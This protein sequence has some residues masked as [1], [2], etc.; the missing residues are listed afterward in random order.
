MRLLCNGVALDLSEGSKMSFKKVNPLF[1]FDSLT[2]ERTQAFDLPATPTNDRV[3]EL[4]KIPA[5]YGAGMRQRFDAELQD[6]TVVKQGYLYV[7]KYAKGKYSAVFVTGELFGLL[8]IKNAG[9]I[10]ELITCDEA[11]AWSYAYVPA[12]PSRQGDTWS[13]TAY[14]Q[15]GGFLHPSYLVRALIDKAVTA[16]TL[17][18]IDIPAAAQYLRVIPAKINTLQPTDSTFVRTIVGNWADVTQTYPY[19]QI[20]GAAITSDGTEIS[21]LFG[22]VM[23]DAIYRRHWEDYNFQTMQPVLRNVTYAGNVLHLVPKQKVKLTFPADFPSDTYIGSFKNGGSYTG[24]FEF[25]GDREFYKGWSGTQPTTGRTGEPLAGR[26]IELDAGKEF[27]FIKES[28]LLDWTKYTEDTTTH[29][30]WEQG[31]KNVRSSISL[32]GITIEGDGEAEIGNTVRLQDNLPDITLVDLLKVIAAL[33]GTALNYTDQDGVTFD[34]L[35]I[36]AWPTV[37][38]K[39]V[40]D[41]TEVTRKFGDY[42][43]RNVLQFDTD[44][45]I[46]SAA[47]VISAYTIQNENLES[48]R[49]L[50]TIPFSEGSLAYLG[51]YGIV[52]VLEDNEKDTIADANTAAAK[53]VRARLPINANLQALCDASTSVTVSARMTLAEY[54]E[55]AAKVTILYAGT[56]YVWTEANWSKNQVTLKLSKVA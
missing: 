23:Y 49:E 4:A 29:E 12:L 26:T 35:A 50:Q 36:N 31:W 41:M 19:P 37:E 25:Y 18:S 56:L 51:E 13:L 39:A 46:A 40:L 44:E 55:L 11:V 14:L 1:A 32:A 21:S 42:G 53:M 24:S 2:C 10:A 45:T 27:V 7:D 38:L 54:E 34:E 30:T 28:D 9:K 5:Y 33:T 48:E 6:G 20:T 17:P 8:K 16:G 52:E 15:D 22:T 43:Q 3:L 47:R